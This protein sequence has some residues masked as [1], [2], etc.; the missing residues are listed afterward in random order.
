MRA[1]YAMVD[2][3]L[4]PAVYWR[5][6]ANWIELS[7]RFLI[8]PRGARAVKDRMSRD[9]LAGLDRAGIGIASAT[10]GIVGLPPVRMDTSDP[11][12]AS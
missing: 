2:A 7:L 4:A 6:T 3:S 11:P 12:D 1:R 5:I 9:I 8:H 10:Y